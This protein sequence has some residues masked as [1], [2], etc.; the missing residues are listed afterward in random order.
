MRFLFGFEFGFLVLFESL[1]TLEGFKQFRIKCLGVF[2][3]KVLQ[4]QSMDPIFRLRQ[5][6]YPTSLREG[7]K[8]YP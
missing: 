1:V 2:E 6:S 7:S 3:A 5:P 8:L 4:H